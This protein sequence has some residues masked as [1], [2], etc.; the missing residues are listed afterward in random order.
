[1]KKHEIYADA[2]KLTASGSRMSKIGIIL[3]CVIGL[4]A[5]IG[6]ILLL[7]FELIMDTASLPKIV[8]YGTEL[9]M[10]KTYLRGKFFAKSGIEVGAEVFVECDTETVGSVTSRYWANHWLGSKEATHDIL[11]VDTQEPSISLITDDMKLTPMDG[12][13]VEE[14]FAAYDDYDG[15]ITGRVSVNVEGDTVTYSVADSSGNTCFAKRKIRYEDLTPPTIVLN[16]DALVVMTVGTEYVELGAT[17]HD[18]SVGDLS[19]QVFV[20]D[21]LNVNELGTYTLRY[22]VQDKYGNGATAYRTVEV[23]DYTIAPKNGK[24]IYLTFDDGPSEHTPRLLDV[25]DKY[26]VKVTF[27][28]VGTSDYIDTVKDIVRRGHTI[29]AHSISHNYKKIYSDDRVFMD[30]LYETQKIIYDLT[31]I[32]T[33]LMRFPG[34]SSNTISRNYSK[35]VMTRL[36]AAV[37]QQGFTYFDWDVDSG[38]TD[39]VAST[40]GEIFHNIT[41]RIQDYEFATILQ[42]DIKGYSVD[43]VESVILWGLENG[44]TFDAL[45]ETGYVAHHEL[46]N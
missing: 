6:G 16:G 14:G 2:N 34:G 5:L 19:D 46:N 33:Y 18:D 39:R 27:F 42:H 26:H 9:P 12:P 28:V 41:T 10:P 1:M 32:K 30:E 4:M 25:L 17:A 38:D 40:P 23:V 24:I 13:Y 7:N 45:S 31:G 43:A 20:S 22:D 44:Y 36:T 21:T 29:G 8:E 35:N 11:V 3:G 37:E 15:D